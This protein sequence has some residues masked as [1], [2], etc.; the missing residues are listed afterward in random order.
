MADPRDLIDRALSAL[1]GEPE[2]TPEEEARS[3][4]RFQS[5]VAQRIEGQPRSISWRL[6]GAAG[7]AVVVAGL[8]LTLPRQETAAAETLREIAQLVEEIDPIEAPDSSF[9]FVRSEEVLLMEVQAE[10]VGR[11]E[12]EPSLFY[13]LPVR[14]D[15]WVGYEGTL[16][17]STTATEPTFFDT[18]DRALYYEFGIDEQDAIGE[19][20]TF[21]VVDAFDTVWATD[22]DELDR[23]IRGMLPLGSTRPEH[24][25]FLDVALQAIRESPATPA[26]RAAVISLLSDLPG[27]ELVGTVGGVSSFSVDFGDND[28]EIRWGFAIDEAGFLRS[29][30]RT[31]LTADGRSGLPAGTVTFEATYS[32]PATVGSLD[33]QP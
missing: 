20:Q 1:Y 31:N 33:P 12:G 10:G 2:P 23:Q 8:L 3:L 25:D 6:A 14:R 21:T 4:A 9:I 32:A 7:L 17:L 29:E 28:L 26:S 27:L 11:Q 15:S 19:T 16:Q 30:S 22:K 24:I 5:A 18:T 13:Q